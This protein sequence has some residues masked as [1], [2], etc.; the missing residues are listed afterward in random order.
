MQKHC[1]AGSPKQ[2]QNC[3][4]DEG[5]SCSGNVAMHAGPE[6]LQETQRKWV[7]GT[8]PYNPFFTW[9]EIFK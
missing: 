7:S 3:Q 2:N 4:R 1:Q 5:T 9:Q 6:V 8:G